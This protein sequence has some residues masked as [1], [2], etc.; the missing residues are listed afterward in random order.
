MEQTK[1]TLQIITNYEDLLR[2]TVNRYN[3]VYKT[4][5]EFYQ[6]V[7]D[8]VYFAIVNYSEAS[9]NDVFQLGVA[10]GRVCEDYDKETSKPPRSSFI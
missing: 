6:F 2:K 9:E 8:E 7:R 3:E 1:K 4:D 5:F 10:F